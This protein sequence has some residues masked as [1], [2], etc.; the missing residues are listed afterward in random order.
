MKKLFPLFLLP[1]LFLFTACPGDDF[2]ED[3]TN[4]SILDNKYAE[5]V[6]HL[7]YD[8]TFRYNCY[9]LDG[10]KVSDIDANKTEIY[11]SRE[12]FKDTDDEYVGYYYTN[13]HYCKSGL[14][15]IKY[16]EDREPVFVLDMGGHDELYRDCFFTVPCY[17]FNIIDDPYKAWMC[18]IAKG[19][20]GI[21]K[22]PLPTTTITDNY[23]YCE[24][25]TNT[26]KFTYIGSGNLTGVSG[27]EGIV[28]GSNTGGGTGTGGNTGGGTSNDDSFYIMYVNDTPS[29]TSATVAFQFSSP[30][31]SATV[32]YGENSCSTTATS[33]IAANRV[34]AYPKNLK[35]G[36]TYMIECTA[37]GKNGITT[38]AIHFFVTRQ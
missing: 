16:N 3:E 27:T 7:L 37:K 15:H 38:T 26:S 6:F 35:R 14:W 21:Y 5:S 28:G 18:V 24:D 17:Y 8:N 32:K 36:T 33:N 25:E 9:R 4:T 12:V 19:A 31:S 13:Y 1:F 22:H 29:Y 11:F 23:L 34:T 2:A 10:S 20:Y 30:V